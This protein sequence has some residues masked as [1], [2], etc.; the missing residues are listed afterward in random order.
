MGSLLRTWRLGS[1]GRTIQSPLPVYLFFVLLSALTIH[2]PFFWD[3]DILFSKLATWLIANRFNPVTPDS[4]DP[5]YPPALA[6][7]L[8]AAWKIAGRQL[9]TVHLL[10]L[11]FALGVVHQTHRF[12]RRIAGESTVVPVL[13]LLAADTTL[14][15]Q[16]VVFS[17][18]LVMLFFMLAGINAIMANRR[19]W[20]A[21]AVVGLLFSHMRGVM[22]AAVLVVFDLYTHR[23]E[24][25]W[26][27]RIKALTFYLPGFLLLAAWLLFHYREKG[28]NGYHEGSPWAGCF[29]RVDLKG[30]MRNMAIVSWRLVDF[31]KLVLW[32]ASA[33]VAITYR[34][35]LKTDRMAKAL[36]FLLA[37]SML[38]SIP[39]MLIYKV[40]N[41]HRYLMPVT[42]I[43]LILTGY[44]VFAVCKA[45]KLKKWLA[46][47]VFAGLASGNFW[48]YP[49]PVAKGWDATLAHL[50]YHAL[51]KKMIEY[52]KDSHI[53]FDEV[54]TEIP[55]TYVF[56]HIDLSGD[57]RSFQQA[58]LLRHRYIFYSNV[59]NTFTD[60]EWKT[61]TEEWTVLARFQCLQVFVVLYENPVLPGVSQP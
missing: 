30:F 27:G 3:K 34:N 44:L 4:L 41:G 55:N 5:G 56:D 15:A 48:I 1:P 26:A 60:T 40:L 45:K 47:G 19:G 10:M 39:T 35:Q 9:V 38:F 29:E 61:L 36:F 54:G 6:Y 53:P 23:K 17:T 11:P 49:D 13:W 59:F 28:W 51:R 25:S 31:G 46:I 14:L 22:V 58:D 57:L 12:I 2:L 33:I 7:L 24:M 32:I 18:D 16:V 52:V 20:L 21:V 50:P 8:A 43:L 37:A 42:F